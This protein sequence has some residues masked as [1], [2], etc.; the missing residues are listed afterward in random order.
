MSLQRL[1][2]RL[3]RLEARWRPWVVAD[4]LRRARQRA[5]SEQGAFLWKAWSMTDRATARAIME[6]L[7]A[8]EL[9]A[10][11]GPELSAFMATLPEAEVEAILRGDLGWHQRFLRSYQ[12]WQNGRP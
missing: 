8:A 12:R 3:T 1:C 10:L 9:D 5:P 2:G 11:L 6:Q 4:V 7:T